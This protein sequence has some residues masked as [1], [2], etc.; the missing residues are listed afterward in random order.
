M[1]LYIEFNI[2]LFI[3]WISNS[4]SKYTYAILLG[5]KRTGYLSHGNIDAETIIVI[6]TFG[7][8]GVSWLVNIS[9]W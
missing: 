2:K 1:I 8:N 9:R 6:N 5:D 7:K 4:V 3:N